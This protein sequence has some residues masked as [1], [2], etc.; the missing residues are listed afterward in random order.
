MVQKVQS[1]D[2]WGCPWIHPKLKGWM[3]R[4]IQDGEKAGKMLEDLLA[5][6]CQLQL[7]IITQIITPWSV[8]AGIGNPK[9]DIM[10]SNS[11]LRCR[12]TPGLE[13]GSTESLTEGRGCKFPLSVWTLLLSTKIPR[14]H[15]S[16][17]TTWNDKKIGNYKTWVKKWRSMGGHSVTHNGKNNT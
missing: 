11:W 12:R 13:G 17:C 14:S 9:V 16:Y 8:P 1:T 4:S 5:Q 15:T 2:A 6:P 10:I 7:K 3:D